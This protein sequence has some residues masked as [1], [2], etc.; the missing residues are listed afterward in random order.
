MKNRIIQIIEEHQLS[1]SQFADKLG[2]PRSGLSHVLSGRNK[3]S[4]DYVLKILEAFP[5]VDPQWLLSG[6]MVDAHHALQSTKLSQLNKKL[7]E[8]AGKMAKEI[9][10]DDGEKE[11]DKLSSEDF[12]IISKRSESSKKGIDRIVI[13]YS[14]GHFDEYRP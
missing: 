6:K 3:P 10:G 5:D 1:N 14:D 4:L 8:Q 11:Q 2:I 7:G 12:E 9:L 13:F